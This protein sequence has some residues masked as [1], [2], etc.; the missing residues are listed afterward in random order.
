[1]VLKYFRLYIVLLY[2]SMLWKLHNTSNLSLEG[3]IR[4]SYPLAVIVAVISDH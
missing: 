2:N 4:N 1:M 3:F